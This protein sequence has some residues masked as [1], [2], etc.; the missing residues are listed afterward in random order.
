MNVAYDGPS[1]KKTN[2]QKW[3]FM[4]LQ[5]LLVPPNATSIKLAF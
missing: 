5:S 2:R 3:Y 1:A 4:A